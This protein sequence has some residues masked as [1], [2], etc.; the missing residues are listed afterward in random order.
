[1]LEAG[2]ALDGYTRSRVLAAT[3]RVM[4]RPAQAAGLA[5][6]QSFFE[7]GMSAF[8]SLAGAT[9]FLRLIED[10]ESRTINDLFTV[11]KEKPD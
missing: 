7:D 5:R 9:D 1:M 3:L 4:R 6:L 10:N 2:R 8:A 11:Q